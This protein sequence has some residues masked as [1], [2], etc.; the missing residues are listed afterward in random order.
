[1]ESQVSLSPFVPSRVDDAV[2][3]SEAY[4]GRPKLHESN[5]CRKDRSVDSSLLGPFVS[6]N[7]RQK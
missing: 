1:M 3:E 6:A 4:K 5:E 7:R 2:Y